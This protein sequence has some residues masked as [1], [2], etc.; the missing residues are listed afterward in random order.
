MASHDIETLTFEAGETIISPGA[1][2][3]SA[4][5]VVSGSVCIED[6]ADAPLIIGPGEMVGDVDVILGQA[7]STAVVA[8]EPVS[9]VR[10]S[11]VQLASALRASQRVSATKM[12]DLFAGFARRIAERASAK[13]ETPN[14]ETDTMPAWHAVRLGADGNDALARQLGGRRLARHDLPVV[15]GRKPG[16][17][18]TA[19]RLPVAIPLDDA[20]PYNLSRRHFAIDVERGVPVVRDVGSL[21]GTLVNGARVGAGRPANTAML[22]IGDNL[23][24]AG[25]AESPFRFILTIETG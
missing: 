23:V 7:Y 12:R 22:E 3:E 14:A 8:L 21:L 13:P 20:K 19:P 18:E 5:V 4:F 16:K 15:V 11:R 25:A 6:T 2:A 24:I 1:N 10:L 9:A 17:R